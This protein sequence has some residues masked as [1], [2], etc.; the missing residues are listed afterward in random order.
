MT[1]G[2][3]RLPSLDRALYA[4][5]SGLADSD[6]H[7]RDR[8]RYRGANLAISFELYLARV[9]GL[10]LGV[11]VVAFW[12]TVGVGLTL[13]AETVAALVGSL[14]MLSP[15]GTGGAP[16]LPR[17]AVATGLGVL[18]AGL[19]GRM[20]VAG[21]RQYLSWRARAR[22]ADI[23]R[24][25]P[26]AVRYLR[27]LSDG[28]DDPREMLGKVAA[29]EEAY[30]ETAVAFRRVLN[31]AALSGSLGEALGLQARDT[32]SREG[33][34][35][36]LLKFREHA[37]Q[38][39]QELATYLRM[40]GRTLGRRRSRARDR[41][42]DFL[43]LV[44]ELFVVLLV[45]P[46]LLVIVVT[47]MSVLSPGLSAP[48]VTPLGRTTWRGVVV[49]A[50][51][52]F[53]LAVGASTVGVIEALR[54][55]GL[56]MRQYDRPSRVRAVVATTSTNP[57][58][59]ALTLTPVGVAVGVAGLAVGQ[60]PGVATLLGYGSYGLC[61][62]VV[63]VRRG[64][65]DDAK[66]RELA[67]FVHAV[68]GHVSLGRPFPSAVEAVA[69]EVD[70]G[71]LDEHVADLA[72]TANLASTPADGVEARTAALDRFVDAVGTP[73]ARQA[74]G[75]VTG[76]LSVGSDADEVFEALQTEVGRLHHEKQALRSSMQVYV[77]VGWTTALLIVGVVV[78]VDAYVLSGFAQLGTVAATTGGVVIEPGAVQP[79]RDGYRFY[80][81]CQAT[82]LA[83]GWFAGTASG[84][85]YEALLHS[86][87]LVL[88]GHAVF[89]G[90]GIL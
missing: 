89:A 84:S 55:A 41:A 44:A 77:A 8:R 20:T 40:E 48:V 74:M 11:A 42:S 45:L 86:G 72:F 10:A 34:A 54:P 25:L 71:P 82:M 3:T 78:A 57:A 17:S 59:A 67:D 53:V 23:E 31:K 60:R 43:E 66:D 70:L 90:A 6:R 32:P 69:R 16:E 76:A 68:S 18:G 87:A 4:L 58:S 50:S 28:S 73:L 49:Y 47:V 26:S 33:L 81:V 30:G 62:G 46:A 36:F 5:F 80:L 14:E 51:V 9:Y 27:T 75:L 79:K 29:N 22:R 19:S 38:G 85:R 13:P 64:R 24:T 63:A 35:P 65:L 37:D 2:E 88:V 52:A 21:G 56:S 1:G 12:V 7:L 83:C 15:V 39:P 61:V